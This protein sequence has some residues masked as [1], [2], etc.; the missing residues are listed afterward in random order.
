M[1]LARTVAAVAILMSSSAT[2]WG[3]KRTDVVTLLNGDR[4]TGEVISLNRG[5]LELKTDDAGTIDIEWNKIAGVEAARGFEIETEDG[6]RVLGSLARAADRGGMV[7]AA[8]EGV[9]SLSMSEVTRITP[10]GTSF[11]RKLDG[12]LDAGFTYSQSSGIAQT[13]L[14]ADTSYRRPAFVV[15]LDGSATLTTRRD[16]TER[17]DRGFMELWYVRYRG[18]RWFVSG[19][20]RFESNESL[21]LLLRSQVA[22]LVGQRIVNTNRAQFALA[23]GL[24][25][26]D[27]RAVDAAPTQNI[28]GVLGLETSYYTYDRPKTQFDARVQYYPSLSN[29]GR[30][31]FQ[32][33]TGLRYELLKDF[34]AALNVYESFDSAPPNL[35]SSRNDVGL[36]FSF[37]WSF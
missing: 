17:D 28:E 3:Q 8:S 7:V 19:A 4:I 14:N 23:A 29:W 37:G 27:E 32:L 35:G 13:T 2:A 34:F 20:T 15:R 22:G 36:S 18:R 10:I 16:D 5:R 9:V 24:V 6:R 25:V 11:W 1:T 21:G 30:Q 31:R 26:N 12:S 33:D